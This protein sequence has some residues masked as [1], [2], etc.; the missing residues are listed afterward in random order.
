MDFLVLLA[1]LAFIVFYFKRKF[2]KIA[3]SV[4][5]IPGP[6][7]LPFIGNAMIFIGKHPTQYMKIGTDFVKTYGLFNRIL[8]GPKILISVGDPED[9]ET[10]L[11]SMKTLEK[12]EEYDYAR[13]WIGDG[14][15]TSTGPKWHSRRKVITPA[16]HFKILQSFAKIFDD[17]SDVFVEK[18]RAFESLDIYPLTALCALD[19]ICGEIR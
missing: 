9:V 3:A 7:P 16:F 5:H 12:S 1:I 2:D 6:A 4:A 17:N 14:L 19:N 10:L 15:I 13:A 8:L 18:L 11:V